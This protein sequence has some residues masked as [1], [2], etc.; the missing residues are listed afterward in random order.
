MSYVREPIPHSHPCGVCTKLK[1]CSC[2]YPA[3]STDFVCDYCHNLGLVVEEPSQVLYLEL[4]TQDID[5]LQTAIL[6]LWMDQ[7][8]RTLADRVRAIIFRAVPS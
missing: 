2:D 5:V 3:V 6:A 7:T 1:P 8:H 4:T